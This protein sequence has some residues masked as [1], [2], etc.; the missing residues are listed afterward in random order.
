VAFES[1]RGDVSLVSR[2][3]VSCAE[4]KGNFFES[5]ENLKFL[6]QS[7]PQAFTLA[8]PSSRYRDSGACCM[9]MAKY[10]RTPRRRTPDE[11]VAFI[12]DPPPD[13]FR[14]E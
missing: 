12:W 9:P 8:A 14:I 3:Y 11:T 7:I 13:R 10:D 6:A 1:I 5:A 4:K 2:T